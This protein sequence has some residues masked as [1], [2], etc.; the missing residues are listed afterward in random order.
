MD[1]T[2][3]TEYRTGL[4]SAIASKHLANPNSKILAILGS[5]VQCTGHFNALSLLYN[6]DEV[7]IWNRN[8]QSAEKAAKKLGD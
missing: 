4:V 7:R 1:G 6:F 2:V 8:I 3:I 5:G